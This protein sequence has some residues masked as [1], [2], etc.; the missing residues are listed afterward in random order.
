MKQLARP[1]GPPPLP[2]SGDRRASGA[3]QR[4]RPTRWLVTPMRNR[5]DHLAKEI[6]QK[7]LTPSGT[8]IAHDEINAETRYADLRHEPDPARH[9][10]RDRLGLLG[11]LASVP[12]V[13]EVYSDAPDAR[14]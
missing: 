7:S 3:D 12:C 4:R 8:T 9:A 5:F 11:R 2:A 13:I 6:G 14:E 10:E 1:A